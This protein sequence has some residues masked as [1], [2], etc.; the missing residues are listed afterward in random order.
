MNGVY[1]LSVFVALLSVAVFS[2][3]A[4]ADSESDSSSRERDLRRKRPK[5]G[6]FS[7]VSNYCRRIA[8]EDHKDEF[9]QCFNDIFFPGHGSNDDS[10]VAEDPGCDGLAAENCTTTFGCMF[11]ESSNTCVTTVNNNACEQHTTQAACLSEESHTCGWSATK[12]KCTNRFKDCSQLSP[13]ACVKATGCM[14]YNNLVQGHK[15]LPR[16]VDESRGRCLA[17]PCFRINNGKCTLQHTGGRCRWLTKAQNYFA[18]YSYPGCYQSPCNNRFSKKACRAHNK[19]EKD[20]HKCTWCGNKIVHKK[21]NGRMRRVRYKLGCQNAKRTSTAQCWNV[22]KQES[23]RSDVLPFSDTKTCRKCLQKGN[24]GT[25]TGTCVFNH[26]SGST[27]TSKE[28]SCAAACCSSPMCKCFN[29]GSRGD[30]LK[31]GA[32]LDIL[33]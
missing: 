22:A 19:N 30:D 26:L 20:P 24:E 9:S 21:I 8:L 32:G 14:W 5:R 27:R 11:S 17:D 16:S 23:P 33:G 2:S 6:M 15:V 4:L 12:S 1:W 28:Q 25:D 10:T 31:E 3:V 29:A 18:N 7:Q 13:E